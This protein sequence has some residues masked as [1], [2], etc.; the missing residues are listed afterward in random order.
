MGAVVLLHILPVLPLA[1]LH[2]SHHHQ[3]RAGDEDQLQRPK[4]N[5]G[6]GEDV[7]VAD[8]GT[9]RLKK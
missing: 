6:D 7:V 3:R 1:V 4:A 8:I 2:V 5:V 9:A